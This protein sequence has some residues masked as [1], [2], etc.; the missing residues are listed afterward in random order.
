MGFIDIF[1]GVLLGYGIFKGIRNGLIVEFASLI[2]FFVG[3]YIAVKFSSVVGGFIGDSKS[4]KVLAFVLT[5]ILVVIGIH[6][7]AKVFSKIASALFLGL[8]NRIGGALFGGLKTALILGVILSLFQ[9][10][11]LNDA[12]ISKETQEESLFFNPI[13]KT[14]EFM[15][16][17][18]T[19]WF[20]DLKSKV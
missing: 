3:I 4:A 18:L 13:L 7:L 8:I 6:L 14:S 19:D 12:L 20:K 9:K 1:L 17:V 11:N 16:P 15:L 2:S 5:F 10:V